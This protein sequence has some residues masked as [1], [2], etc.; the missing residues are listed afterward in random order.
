MGCTTV[1]WGTHGREL[2]GARLCC[3]EHTGGSDGVHDC[4]VGNTR[5]GVMGCTT[6]L[7]GTHGRE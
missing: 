5:E 6:V 1:L 7:W 4:A 2:W 3:G